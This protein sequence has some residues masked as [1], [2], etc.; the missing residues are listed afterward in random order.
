MSTS[1]VSCPQLAISPKVARAAREIFAASD[2]RNPYEI[3]EH[4][5]ILRGNGEDCTEPDLWL[6]DNQLISR[7]DLSEAVL[8]CPACEYEYSLWEQ[9][10]ERS[11]EDGQ[12]QTTEYAERVF[13]ALSVEADL[14]EGY[15]TQAEITAAE[16]EDLR[17][18]QTERQKREAMKAW[19]REQQA[20]AQRAQS[21]R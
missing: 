14:K 11:T 12:E 1:I 19:E 16:R 13:V 15:L 17:I 7:D 8:F 10:L 20:A 18:V 3:S 9:L 21:R 5:S 4:L 2:G 6:T